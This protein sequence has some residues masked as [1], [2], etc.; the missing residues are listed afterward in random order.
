MWGGKGKPTIGNGIRRHRHQ[1]GLQVDIV[2]P[3]H[4]GRREERE[5]AE[6]H[7]HAKVD[8]VV[9]V[10]PPVGQGRHCV[11]PGHAAV[12]ALAALDAEPLDGDVALPAPEELLRVVGQEDQHQEG[13]QARRGALDDEQPSPGRQAAGAVHVADGVGDG[14]AKGA[15]EGGAGEDE[16]D[17]HAALVGAVPEGQVVDEAREEAGLEDA[18]QEA[19]GG[20]GGEGVHGAEAHGDGAP[21]EHE[22]GEPARGAQLLEQDVGRH[23]EQGVADEEDHQGDVELVLGRADLGLHVVARRRVEDARVA[24]VGAVEVAEEVNE[25]REGQDGEV[26]LPQQP[27]LLLF[28][29]FDGRDGLGAV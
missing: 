25:G 17:A 27:A 6:G 5:R 23:L 4:D 12:V 3:G 20:G 18:E 1:L 24:D 8:E 19:D 2:Q 15:G 7:R 11:P 26:L 10:Q 28:G 14:A 16:G 13:R 21:R 22:E 9:P 29:E